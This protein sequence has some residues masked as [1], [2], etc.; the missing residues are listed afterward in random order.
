MQSERLPDSFVGI[1]QTF[2]FKIIAPEIIP[3]SIKADPGPELVSLESEPFAAL[4]WPGAAAIIRRDVPDM[5]SAIRLWRL[6]EL[7]WEVREYLG[8][9]LDVLT[10]AAYACRERGPDG[11]GA[12][13]GW[14]LP[15]RWQR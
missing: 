15:K 6:H 9:A 5:C 4:P 3:M 7:P 11:N 13:Q 14:E 2:L 10:E 1:R 12:G 8:T